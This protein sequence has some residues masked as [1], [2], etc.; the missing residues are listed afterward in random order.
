MRGGSHAV[1]E[2]RSDDQSLGEDGI[3]L[4]TR[5]F[6]EAELVGYLEEAVD[7][8]QLLEERLAELELA[9]EDRDWVRI[10][11]D[12]SLDFSAWAL[13]RIISNA[14]YS[15]LHNPLIN[16]G[17]EIKTDYVWAKDMTIRA[18]TEDE[19][20]IVDRFMAHPKNER[21]L[22]DFEAQIERDQQVDLEGNVFLVMV[23]GANG[24]CIVRVL[25]T[26][27]I[28]DGGI[29]RNPEDK[30]EV[31]YYH[32]VWVRR[33]NDGTSGT[34]KH[35]Y[36]PDIRYA[37]QDSRPSAYGEGEQRG[38]IH[39]D[40]P[41]LHLKDGGLP[42]G[43]WGVPTVYQSIDW[44]REVKR[45][46]EAYATIRRALASFAFKLK[47]KGGSKA[48]SSAKAR[49]D[50]MLQGDANDVL[51]DGNGPPVMG[52]TWIEGETR[53]LQPFRTAGVTPNP[54]E[55]RR[56]WNMTGAGMGLPETM[57][58]GDADVG[59]LATA[60]TLD[61]PTELMMKRRQ[62][63]WIAAYKALL[64]YAILKKKAP[65]NYPDL[66]QPD[67]PE[68]RVTFPALLERDPQALLTATLDALTYAG[69]SLSD[70]AAQRPRVVARLLLDAAG[71]ED[72]EELLDEFFD[73]EPKDGEKKLV[74][75]ARADA[76]A[77]AAQ[78]GAIPPESE[79]AVAEAT[80]L[81][82]QDMMARRAEQRRLSRI[83]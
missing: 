21:V 25:P 59:N 31:W 16:H 41:V 4:G 53:D 6:T 35:D 57:L 7:N 82:L 73:Q 62:R 19:Q 80:R 8:Q 54:E 66:N 49:L 60:T 40:M 37:P 36:Y 14:R 3:K 72:V 33:D 29:I 18:T 42:G 26:F 20:K 74:D 69:K 71:L 39:W 63:R 9:L 50:S 70:W 28:I 12:G 27:E 47:T 76:E 52:S 56:L 24:D 51:P 23:T 45:D 30:A 79:Q 38:D 61:R 64:Q 83:G 68:V 65:D 5:S 67:L 15:Y 48:I 17:V 10:G 58:A 78:M 22:T 43:K 77:M 2:L 13:K 55:G 32:R 44:A 11:E 81:L 46:L 1:A 34:P 75:Q